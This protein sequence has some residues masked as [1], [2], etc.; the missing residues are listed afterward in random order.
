MERELTL[1]EKEVLESSS[2][3]LLWQLLVEEL[4]QHKLD[5]VVGL[6]GAKNWE[7]HLVWE[8]RISLIEEL[9]QLPQTLLSEEERTRTK[10]E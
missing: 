2:S 6:R 1:E 7:E 9:I 5:C 10:E 3:N 4:L 8:S